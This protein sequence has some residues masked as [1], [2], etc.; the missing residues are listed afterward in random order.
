MANGPGILYEERVIHAGCR[1]VGAVVLY[2]EE[3]KLAG[4]RRDAA[5]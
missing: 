5:I 4:T 2:V 1:T 3:T